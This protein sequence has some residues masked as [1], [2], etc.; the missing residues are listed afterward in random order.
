[1]NWHKK[2]NGWEAWAPKAYPDDRFPPKYQLTLVQPRD[3]RR[4]VE[5]VRYGRDPIKVGRGP[6]ANL[7]A[8]KELA[9]A[10]YK[11]RQQ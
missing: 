2:Q 3:P 9:E 5:L 10:D 8:A 6:A 7:A 1:M 4:H 11:R